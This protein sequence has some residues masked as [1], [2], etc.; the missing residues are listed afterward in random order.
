M[1]EFSNARCKK[2]WDIGYLYLQEKDDSRLV[3][4]FKFTYKKV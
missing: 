4:F 2:K 1:Q 3:S